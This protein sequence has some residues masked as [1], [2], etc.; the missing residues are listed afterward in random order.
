MCL[1]L[2]E[3][4]I[5]QARQFLALV[6]ELRGAG[7][8]L[9]GT[10]QLDGRAMTEYLARLSR[11]QTGVELESWQVPMSTFWLTDEARAVVGISR[12][13]HRL[14]PALRLHGGHIGFL[15]RPSA[16]RRGF[17]RQLLAL[18]L[19][20]ARGLGLGRVLLTCD[21]DNAGSRR[22]IECNGGKLEVEAVSPES[23]QLI[24]RYWID[25]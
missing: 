25:L 7:Q 6:E 20:R 5:E 15:V 1:A 22:I 16:R 4:S 23:G 3:P 8:P 21:S 19:P 9:A 2:V 24:R 10:E 12:I 13:R 11:L 18:S 14:T 17:G